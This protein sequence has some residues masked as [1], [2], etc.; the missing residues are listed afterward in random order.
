[1]DVYTI[2]FYG[3]IGGCAPELI[4][5]H[6]IM[7]EDGKFSYPSGLLLVSLLVAV[8]GG[9]LA[10]ALASNSPLQSI[11]IGASTP[12]II[13]KFGEKAPPGVG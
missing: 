12:I 11:W 5:I 7:K 10:F 4:R 13:S 1:M 3:F 2:F 9:L 8:L 6:K